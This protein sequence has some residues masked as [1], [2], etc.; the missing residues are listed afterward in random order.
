MNH[1]SLTTTRKK[2]MESPGHKYILVHISGSNENG[3]NS[4]CQGC[5]RWKDQQSQPVHHQ[6][7]EKVNHL[8]MLRLPEPSRNIAEIIKNL[9][10]QLQQQHQ[11]LRWEKSDQYYGIIL[12]W[13]LQEERS[14]IC[15]WKPEDLGQLGRWRLLSDNRSQQRIIW[16]SN[17][18]PFFITKNKEF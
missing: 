1:S 6:V 11:E 8:D 4:N 3:M 5:L 14:R 2:C 10:N 9:N 12:L 15:W 18:I 7:F 16:Y 13:F 17:L